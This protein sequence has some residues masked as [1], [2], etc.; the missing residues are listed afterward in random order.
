VRYSP[1]T[2]RFALSE[3][4]SVNYMALVATA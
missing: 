4:L 2:G 1:L 3:D